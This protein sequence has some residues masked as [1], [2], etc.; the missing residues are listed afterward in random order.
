MKVIKLANDISLDSSLNQN[1]IVIKDKLIYKI[2]G[3]FM[4]LNE[5]S[6]AKEYPKDYQNKSIL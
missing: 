6:L 3:T 4:H 5:F 2:N 1:P